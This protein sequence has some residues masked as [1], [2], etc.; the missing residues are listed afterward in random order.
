MLLQLLGSEGHRATGCI[1]LCRLRSCGWARR[2]LC[3]LLLLLLAGRRRAAVVGCCRQRRRHRQPC[4]GGAAMRASNHR[5]AHARGAAV[6][7]LG[8]EGDSP[9]AS[10]RKP[11]LLGRSPEA[12]CARHRTAIGLQGRWATRRNGRCAGGLASPP[13]LCAQ[14][15]LCCLETDRGVRWGYKPNFEQCALQGSRR[16]PHPARHALPPPRPLRR[17]A[18][19]H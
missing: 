2:L 11:R 9:R 10:A 17:L 19:E 4:Q 14:A 18:L 5:P 1:R 6:D 15:I 16:R 12:A 13:K 8:G 7:S 3:R